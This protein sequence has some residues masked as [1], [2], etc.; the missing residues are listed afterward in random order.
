MRTYQISRMSHWYD[1][2]IFAVDKQHWGFH[3]FY[4]YCVIELILD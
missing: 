3:R 2:V 4:S 1:I